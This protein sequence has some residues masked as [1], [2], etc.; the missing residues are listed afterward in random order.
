M[1]EINER[2]RRDLRRLIELIGQRRVE[3]ELSVHRTTVQRWL[4][5]RVRI[6]GSQLLAI[7]ALL[8]DHPGTAGKW[9]SWRFHDGHLL[10]PAG[11][12][13]TAGDVMAIGLNRQRI[14]WLEREVAR[15]RARLAIVEEDARRHTGA[16]NEDLRVR[17]RRSG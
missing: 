3:R 8:G 15:L 16:A 6:P 14:A 4:D 5:G 13:Y 11:D 1:L 17:A 10:S 7:R 12:A 9:H 2:P